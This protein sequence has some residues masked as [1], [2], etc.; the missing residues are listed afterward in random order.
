RA[1]PREEEV[2]RELLGDRG[3]ARDDAALLRVLLARLLDRL[4]I[5][6]LMIDEARVFR[7]HDRALEA[8]RDAAIGH[9]GMAELRRRIAAAQLREPRLHEGGDLRIVVA[10]PP[11]AR[12]V[13]ELE[14]EKD[15]RR[16]DREP[17]AEPQ[18]PLQAAFAR[19]AARTSAVAGLRPRHRR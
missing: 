18:R 7:H 11:D 12:D 8:R 15:S 5:E 17:G 4:P 9:P 19:S 14:R 10:P 1:L 6:A 16:G 13:G 2:L 3:P